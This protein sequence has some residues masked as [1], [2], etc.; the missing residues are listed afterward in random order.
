M[1]IFVSSTFRDLRAERDAAVEALRRSGLVPWGMELFISEPATPLQVALEELQMSD[2]VVLLIGFKAGS[3]IPDDPTLTYTGAEFRRAQDLGKPIFVFLK[4]EAG[5][6][7]NEETIPALK[8]ALDKFK[9]TVL[10][11]GITPGYFDS[12]DRLQIELLLAMEKWNAEGRPGARLVFTTRE[13]FLAPYRS[14][15]PRLFDFN[16]TLRGRDSEVQALN[17]FLATPQQIV[18]ILTGRGGI[19]KSKLLHDWTGSVPGAKIL[20]VREDADWH[21]EAAKE[22]PAGDVV[23]VVDD[24]HRLTFLDKLL[25]AVRDLQ[26]KRSL[27]LVLG[28]RPSGSGPI[29]AALAPRLDP[30]QVERFRQ[31]ERVGQRSVIELATES[32]GAGHAQYAPALA[33]VSSDT[34]LVTVVGGRLIA[35]GDISPALL[36]NE[37]D[38]RR[39]VFDRFS[40]EYERLLPAGPVNWRNLLNLIAALGPVEPADKKFQTPSADLLH[41]RQDE[42]VA[43]VD[44]LQRNGLLLRA[45]RLVRIVPDLLSDFLLEGACVTAGGESTGFAD[46]VFEKFPPEY[47]SRLLRN[48]GELD[49]RITQRN[50]DQG[51][52]LLDQIWAEINQSFE[53]S[54]ASDRVQLLKALG[55]AALFQPARTMQLIRQAMASEA[56]EKVLLTDW[57]ITQEHVIREIPSLLRVIA[58]HEEHFDEAADLLWQLAQRDNRAPNQ[59]PEHAARALKDLAEYGRYKPVVINDRMAELVACVIRQPEA[60][61]GSFTP[62]DIADKLLAKE[63]EFTESEGFTI[64]IGGFA[65]NYPAIRPIREKTLR[66]VDICLNSE[67]PKASRRAVESLAHV[68]SGFLPAVVRQATPEEIAWQ[69][70]ERTTALQIL[71]SRL[72][73]EKRIPITRQIRSV[74]RRARPRNR[75]NPIGQRI[76]EILSSVPPTDDLLI[77][78]AFSTGEWELDPEFD[79]IEEAGQARRARLL[80]GVGLF[81]QKD[82]TPER[83]I[84][85][86]I[87][88][89]KEG[90]LSGTP[91]G[92]RCYDF[93]DELCSDPAFRDALVAYVQQDDADSLLAQMICIPLRRLR[94]LDTARYREVGVQCAAH[95][96]ALVAY[97]TANAVSYGPN[98]NAP[99]PEDLSILAA[100]ADHPKAMVRHLTFTGIRRIGAHAEYECEAVNLLI[101]SD[102][103]DDARMADEMCGAV[104]YAG[105]PLGNLSEENIR[106]LLRKLVLTKEIDDHQNHHIGRFLA[107]VGQNRPAA[108]CEF[109]IQRLDR[110]AELEKS[111][112][113]TGGYAPVPHHRFGGAFHALQGT[114][115]YL[116]FLIQVRDRFVSLPQQRYWLREL[117]WSIGTQDST[118]LS[119]IDDLLHSDDAEQTKAAIGLLE[120][121]PAE[122]AL[123]CPM[124]AAHVVDECERA[125]HQLGEYAFS[126][127]LGN[128]HSGGFQRAPG[129][130][131]PKYLTMRD[132][133]AALQESFPA[134]SLGR[135]LYQK[136]HDSAVAEMDRERKD[137]EQIEFS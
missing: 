34:P 126:A 69:D 59:Y 118:T 16:Q 102:I 31:L 137:D 61:E 29:D 25:I 114:N 66:L 90:E 88:L 79:S 124:F 1:R 23:I 40:N 51:S 49:W 75:E 8:E 35:R 50:Q 52:R 131:S 7:R 26:G 113:S 89:I 85:A 122:L 98:L 94:S 108:L 46:V 97:G 27:K 17:Q 32:L 96:N 110:Y 115:H 11:S 33:A 82:P 48:L 129:Q 74:L 22:I 119:A 47:L 12:P 99:I 105:I 111:G 37:E 30:T 42:V 21:P 123:N 38:F 43:A 83:Q 109:I 3:L 18:G 135:R 136:L 80:R 54:D 63:G 53:A 132:R 15:T 91:I 28:T 104:D 2:A 20:Y 112:Q 62:L 39:E 41:V 73:V 5:A 103:G 45:G 72:R 87:E 106:A 55:D 14:A 70:Q 56:K 86:M 101:R 107:W 67:N 76:T 44:Q 116:E 95:K 60:F 93:I 78:D 9:Q 77:F 128:A 10:D 36:A 58:L 4:T 13:E 134:G 130:P 133:S 57:K 81:R 121:A 64:S 71:E 65:L 127:L 100:L 84:Q 19:G 24:A 125:S 120:G 117:F 6:W 68:L 92:N